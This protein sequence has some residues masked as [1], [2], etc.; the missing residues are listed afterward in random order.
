MN[1]RR[2]QLFASYQPATKPLTGAARGLL[3][4]EDAQVEAL[5]IGPIRRAVEDGFEFEP[6]QLVRSA[7]EDRRFGAYSGGLS[8]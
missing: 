8:G 6:S 5:Q 4:D 3:L 7:G 2:L 1:W